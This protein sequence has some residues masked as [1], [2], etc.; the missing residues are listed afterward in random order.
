MMMMALILE[1]KETS[2]KSESIISSRSFSNHF[3]VSL[4]SYPNITMFTMFLYVVDE[5][6]LAEELSKKVKVLCW[7]MTNPSNIN[8]KA[9]HLKATWGKR[10]NKLLFMSSEAEPSLPA[11]GLNISEGRDFLWGKTRKAFK[12]IYENH[13]M[14]ADWFLKADDD[15]YVIMENLRKLLLEYKPTVPLYFGRR[16]K[17]YVKQGYMSGGA[18]YVLSRE[19]V[20][21]FVEQALNNPYKCRQDF[22]GAE[23]VEIGRCVENVGV[24]ARDSRDSL[25][26][27]T[28]NPFLPEHHLIPGL[29]GDDNWLWSYNYYPYK[30]VMSYISKYLETII[31]TENCS[32]SRTLYRIV[33]Q[34]N[35]K[36][37]NIGAENNQ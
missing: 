18:G 13:L 5:G 8:S 6:K 1:K 27:E 4:S 35:I 15:T 25:G 37:Q 31:Y 26:R 28:F 16:F 36:K 12:Y 3:S 10:C 20:K 7:V 9:K 2:N 29:I 11:I 30:Q 19:G 34:S 17:P 23:D 21:H 22:G 24:I 14:D 32:F 33:I